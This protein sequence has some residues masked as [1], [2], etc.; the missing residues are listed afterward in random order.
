M[1]RTLWHA[2]RSQNI[3][4]KECPAATARIAEQ[5]DLQHLMG[6]AAGALSRGQ[7]QRLAIARAMITK[8]KVIL[9]DEPTGSLD[10]VT[11]HDIM[12]LFQTIN[13]SGITIAVVTHE[14]DIA[15]MTDRII[16]IKDGVIEST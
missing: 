14:A 11:S 13:R 2:A 16:R 4:V 1:R 5:L 12:A 3:P 8:P 9:A 10:S 6:R 7:R 15:A